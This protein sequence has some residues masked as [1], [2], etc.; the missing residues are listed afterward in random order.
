MSLMKAFWGKQVDFYFAV[1]AV[2]LLSLELHKSRQCLSSGPLPSQSTPF[3]RPPPF[4]FPP[5]RIF[6]FQA[7]SFHPQPYLSLRPLFPP[8]CFLSWRE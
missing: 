8:F 5:R 1:V 2:V 3:V 7:D 4:F 6:K